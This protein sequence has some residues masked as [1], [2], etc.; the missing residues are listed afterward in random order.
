[1]NKWVRVIVPSV[2]AGVLVLF[3]LIFSGLGT[4]SITDAQGNPVSFTVVSLDAN[5]FAALMIGG[6][7]IAVLV[8]CFALEA[9]GNSV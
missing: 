9:A 3:F 7:F 8:C 6:V 5:A 2:V 4:T 1:M